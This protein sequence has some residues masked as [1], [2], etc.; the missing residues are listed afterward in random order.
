[1]ILKEWDVRS[2]VVRIIHFDIFFFVDEKHVALVQSQREGDPKGVGSKIKRCENNNAGIH[3]I[4]FLFLNSRSKLR[5]KSNISL[6]IT[7]F[8]EKFSLHCSKRRSSHV[9]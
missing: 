4:H 2:K 8:E 7:L 3:L 6:L 5:A 1:M 9:K